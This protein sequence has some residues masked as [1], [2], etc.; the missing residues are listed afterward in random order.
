MVMRISAALRDVSL[1]PEA[2]HW[3]GCHTAEK[4]KREI[5][6]A[7]ITRHWRPSQSRVVGWEQKSAVE[8]ETAQRFL[9]DESLETSS[10]RPID[11]EDPISRDTVVRTT[12][13]RKIHFY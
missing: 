3:A 8:N 5:A 7:G 1:S 12:H 9:P 4:Q 11:R 6:S 2:S 13:H 10:A